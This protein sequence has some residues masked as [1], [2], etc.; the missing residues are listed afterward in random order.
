VSVNLTAGRHILPVAAFLADHGEPLPPLLMQAGL[1]RTC[2]DDPG[3]LVPTAALWHFRELAEIRTG[4]SDLA[5]TVMDPLAVCDL[6]PVGRSLLAAPTLRQAI[7][8]FRRNA[9]AESSTAV[10]S[11]TPDRNGDALFSVR[12]NLHQQPGEWQ[13]EL[14]LLAWMLKIVWLFDPKWSPTEIWCTANATIDRLRVIE[15]LGARPRFN[16]RCTGFPIPAHMLALPQERPCE[17]R[18]GTHEAL[19]WSRAPSG[20]ASG[21]VKQMIQTYADERWLTVEEASD[22]LGMNPRTLQRQLASEDQTYSAI[23]EETRAEVA[24]KLLKGM[25]ASLSEIA[26]R[27]GYSNLSNFNRAFRRWASVSPREFREQRRSRR[28]HPNLRV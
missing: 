20:S 18:P 1:P 19:L 22:G 13:A 27:L 12:F 16:Q 28:G 5:L 9:W 3:K 26:R 24:A 23:L 25:E 2:L 6:G 15:S 21:A 11:I 4:L 14:Y 10:L 8:D 7:E 17:P